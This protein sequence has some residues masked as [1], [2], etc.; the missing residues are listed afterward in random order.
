[1]ATVEIFCHDTLVHTTVSQG[2]VN[3]YRN[4]LRPV[5]RAL[6][7]GNRH[8]MPWEVTSDDVVWL[9]EDMD[10]RGLAVQTRHGYLSALRQWTMFYGNDAVSKAKIRLPHDMRPNVNWIN[11]E[12]AD[13]LMHLDMCP[14]DELVVHCELC[15]GMRRIEVLRLTTSSFT[16]IY[17]DILGKGTCG[18]KPRR[19]PYHRDTERIVGRYMSYRSGMAALAR[20]RH[21]AEE[22]TDALLVWTDKQKRLHAYCKHGSAIDSRLEHLGRRAG[23]ERRLSNHTLRRTFG[24]IMYRSGVAPATIS[25]MLGHDSIEQT[26]RYIGVDLDDMTAAMEQYQ[27]K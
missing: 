23:I 15:L 18:G 7:R 26:L 13:T 12:Q 25:K 9:T 24:R 4:C 22:I 8:S 19:M 17:V 14:A 6:E 2:T 27:L 16:G 5:I 21:P 3:G 20:T 1:M 10:A 11:L